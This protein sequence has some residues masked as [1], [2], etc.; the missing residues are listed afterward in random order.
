MRKEPVYFQFAGRIQTE[1]FAV[2]YISHLSLF[3]LNRN[4]ERIPENIIIGFL[5]F[6]R[7]FVSTGLLDS[8]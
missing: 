2:L 7:I 4:P 8:N 3:K 1:V 6:L 5:I